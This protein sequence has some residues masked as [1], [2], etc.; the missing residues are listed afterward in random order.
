VLREDTN[1]K[2]KKKSD[3]EMPFHIPLLS[4]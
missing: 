3:A 4:K 1:A 2:P